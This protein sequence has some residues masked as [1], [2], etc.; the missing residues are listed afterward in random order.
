MPARMLLVPDP[1]LEG[2]DGYPGPGAALN[3]ED[4]RTHMWRKWNFVFPAFLYKVN[5]HTKPFVPEASGVG[6]EKNNLAGRRLQEREQLKLTSIHTRFQQ[7]FYSAQYGCRLET[8]NVA[9]QPLAPDGL[10]LSY[11]MPLA[12]FMV[13]GVPIQ[14]QGLSKAKCVEVPTLVGSKPTELSLFSLE[15]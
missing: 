10:T 3:V 8:H 1:F 4:A 13:R 6:I 14:F 7:L 12:G 2:F 9:L 5:V 15:P 11:E